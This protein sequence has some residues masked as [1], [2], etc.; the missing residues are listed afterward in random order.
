MG[1]AA[2]GRYESVYE[3]R[4]AGSNRGKRPAGADMDAGI[5]GRWA[6]D[7]GRSWAVVSCGPPGR[8]PMAAGWW[9]VEEGEGDLGGEV[10]GRG[11]STGGSSATVVLC[12]GA[13]DTAAQRSVLV[14]CQHIVQR[15]SRSGP[16]L[17]GNHNE[18]GSP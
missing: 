2:V 18:H 6:L 11:A 7:D 1:I 17:L 8:L 15:Q 5:G 12:E 3:D 9:V 16:K 14:V 13:G 10:G 4:S